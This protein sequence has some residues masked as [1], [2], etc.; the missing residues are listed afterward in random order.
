MSAFEYRHSRP[1]A[2]LETVGGS[3]D[4]FLLLL[5]IFR[6][7]T[8]DKLD[9]MRQA[10][11]SGDRARLGFHTHALK[12]TVGPAGADVLLQQLV[13]L[14]AA[15]KD[16]LPAHD[17]KTLADIEQQVAQVREELERFAASMT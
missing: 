4:T 7:D 5:D 2:L 8:A 10:L 17:E 11:A 6:R 9:R 3:R 13:V 16:P 1:A 15:C 14:E 12:G